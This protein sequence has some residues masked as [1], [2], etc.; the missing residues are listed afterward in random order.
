MFHRVY[1]LSFA[2]LSTAKLAAGFLAEKIGQDAARLAMEQVEVQIDAEG[3]VVV[4]A[5]FD[6]VSGV[7][8]FEKFGDAML[9][10]LRKSCPCK[11]VK[12]STITTFRYDNKLSVGA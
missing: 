5:S 1:A 8:R 10:E 2:D 6:K 12:F 11:S 4:L 9:D 3:G 7:K